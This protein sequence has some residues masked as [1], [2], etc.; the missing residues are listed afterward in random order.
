VQG[1]GQRILVV[2]DEEALVRMISRILTKLGYQPTAMHDSTEALAAFEAA[3]GDFD[4]ILSDLTMPGLTGL[5]LAGHANRIRPGIPVIVMTGYYANLS[6]SQ[7]KAAG[8]S[9]I[10]MKPVD[11]KSLSVVIDQILKNKTL[12]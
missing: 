10:M 9:E 7:L 5:E 11:L 1:G 4:L 6:E 12:V 8:V 2:D 3:P